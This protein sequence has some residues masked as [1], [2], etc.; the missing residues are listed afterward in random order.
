M[1]SVIANMRANE[2]LRSVGRL[3]SVAVMPVLG[4]ALALRTR[5][6]GPG[7]VARRLKH[8]APEEYTG[9]EME[10]YSVGEA[11]GLLGVS[12]DTVR[13]W[14]DN[15][16][17]DATRTVNGRRRIEGVA[18]A[19]F[20]QSLH[21][22]SDAPV[23]NSASIRNHFTGI[24]TKVVKDKVM[25]QVELQAGPFRVVALISREAVDDLGLAPGVMA[26]AV[27]KS[28]NVSIEI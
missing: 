8:R 5:L 27:V 20:A 3:L 4:Y 13:R 1:V 24:V 15:G 21:E 11:A 22:G 28:T 26:S 23:A 16:S 10:D 2:S 25:A 9:G 18:L 19:K 12:A 6:R 14:I 7:T 17:L